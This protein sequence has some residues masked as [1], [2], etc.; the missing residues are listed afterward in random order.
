MDPAG[1]LGAGSTL[2]SEETLAG[3][4]GSPSKQHLLGGTHPLFLGRVLPP[5]S[6]SLVQRSCAL[7]QQAE[8]GRTDPGTASAGLGRA[9]QPWGLKATQQGM[10]EGAGAADVGRGIYPFLSFPSVSLHIHLPRTPH[11]PK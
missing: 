11:L 3:I 4:P 6:P 10:G 1:G 5:S 9:V 8:S 2:P 7:P